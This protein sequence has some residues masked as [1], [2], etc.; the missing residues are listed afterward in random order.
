MDSDSFNPR[1]SG[2]GKI[3]RMARLNDLE[4]TSIN[5]YP[6]CGKSATS[7]MT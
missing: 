2:P 3:A 7:Q 5:V 4:L 6:A 1:P